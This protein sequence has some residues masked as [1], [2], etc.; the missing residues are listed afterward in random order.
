MTTFST[1][2]EH[3]PGPVFALP[4][5]GGEGGGPPSAGDIVSM[6]RRRIVLIVILFI[7]F[8]A[9]A[10]AGFWAWWTYLPSYRAECQIQCISNIPDS[11]L[12]VEQRQLRQDEHERFVM[13]QALAL[14]TP[15]ILE[16]ALRTAAVRETEWFKGVQR[17]EEEPLLK[18]EDKLRAAPVRGTDILKVWIECHNRKD[19][20]V[21]VNTVVDR[22]YETVERR[23]AQEFASEPLRDAQEQLVA[24]DAQIEE[25]RAQ[26][27]EIAMRLPA[28]ARQNP[29]NNIAAQ[30]VEQYSAQ[31]AELTLEMSQLEQ[32]RQIYNDPAGVPVTAE[33]RALVEQDPQV[34]EL[35]RTLFLLEQQ[36]AADEGVFGPEHREYRQLE[37]RIEAIAD[38]LANLRAEK[39]TERRE[40]IREATNTAYANAQ[41]ALFL[42]RENLAMSEAMLQDQDQLLFNY[43]T[44]QEDLDRDVA[45][46]AQLNEV[47]QSL[48]RVVR[49]KG[50]VNI[51]ILQR[52]IDPL[53]KSSPSLLVLPV[54]IVLAL[55][56][57]IGLALVLEL[58]DKS[59]RTPKDLERYLTVALLGAVPDTDDEEVAIKQVETVVRDTP[60]SM[61][62][63]AFRRVRTS[64]RFST[65]ADRQRCVVVTSPRPE[66]G[67]T[68]VA[69]NLAL[70]IAQ[71]GRRVLLMDANFRRPGIHKQFDKA[72]KRGL[73]N[74]LIGD[75][76]LESCVSSTDLP[77]LNVLGSG[78]IPPNP[79]E[80][81]GSEAFRQL[82]GKATEDYDQV[83]IDTAPV[84]L[85]SDALVL[86]SADVGV[87]LV[88][89]ANENTRGA[90]RRAQSL[91]D[92]VNAC[93]LG[94]VLNAVQSTRGGYF[95]E[96]LHDYYEYQAEVETSGTAKPPQEP[97]K[98]S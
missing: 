52:A 94:S 15:S 78:P 35:A 26:Q 73:S 7:L 18:L 66:D 55:A 45:Y 74:I 27:R 64:M 22:W 16:D 14:R 2:S 20:A 44:L 36:K 17:R 19:P 58:A 10:V 63:E 72:A 90:V 92:G 32:F 48:N 76:T 95:R 67:K 4:R 68:T 57:A 6:L 51:N 60:R 81:L 88:V 39:L 8:S 59:I 69:C 21:L 80:L 24:I 42:A 46:R 82:L 41:H 43:A 3:G 13:T 53:E 97:G 49:Q 79:T 30:Q 86:A 91:L 54:G 9:M 31:V 37:A 89:R 62:A 40:D 47:I 85:T 87:I 98:P 71:G 77:A 29:A 23:A 5:A 61:V 93:V 65:T 38:K 84:L 25:K 70:A 33:D 34:A 11:G 96:Q 1:P 28:G 56:V 75:E 50:A 12:S 83:I